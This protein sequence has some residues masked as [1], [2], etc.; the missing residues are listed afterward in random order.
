MS[1]HDAEDVL[2]KELPTRAGVNL[3]L[4]CLSAAVLLLEISLTRYFSFRLWYHYAFMIISIAMLGLTGSSIVLAVWRQRFVTVP[5]ELVASRCAFLAGAAIIVALPG[6]ALLNRLWT[7][8]GGTSLAATFGLVAGYWLLLVVPFGFAGA[9]IG[10]VIGRNAQAA[11]RL[12]AFDLV[13]ASLGCL[14][15]VGLLSRLVPERALG[16]VAAL[17]AVA[18]WLFASESGE[19]RRRAAPLVLGLMLASLAVILG[20]DRLLGDRVTAEKGLART[21][22]GGGR[23]VATRPSISGRVDVA[24]QPGWHLIWGASSLPMSAMPE[25]LL[26]FI[27]GDALTSIT[28]R[29]G[30]ERPLAFLKEMPASLP[31]AVAAPKR[32]LIIGAGGGMDVLNALAHGSRDVTGVEINRAVIEMVQGPFAG[33]S[34]DLYRDPRVRVV[35]SDG[36]NFAQGA[37]EKYDLIQMTLDDS[38]AAISS[39]ALTLAEDFLYTTEGFRAYIRAL[40]SDGVLALGRTRHEYLSLVAMLDA[41]ASQEGIDVREHLLLA[42]NP[43]NSFGLVV[44]FQKSPFS[45]EQV[46]A[47]ERFLPRAHLQ[48]IY[49]P[50]RRESSRSEVMSLLDAPN[51]AQFVEE[52]SAK[53]RDITPETDEKPFYFRASKWTALLGKHY[54]G[55]GTL[56]VILAVALVFVLLGVLMPLY[57]V[58]GAALPGNQRSLAFFFFIG[59]GFMALEMGLL[60]RLGLYLGHPARAITVAL[61]GLLISTGLGSACARS[62]L[63]GDSDSGFAATNVR[64]LVSALV[65]VAVLAM[66]SWRFQP[67]VIQATIGWS[68]DARLLVAMLLV[69]PLGLLLGAPMPLGLAAL[70]RRDE[71]LVLWAWGL[72]GSASVLGSIVT[73]IAAHAW[74][75]GSAFLIASTCYL[76]ASLCVGAGA[77][78][79]RA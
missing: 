22:A 52:Y 11:P 21:L 9:G 55:S 1:I 77:L 2:P 60:V 71:R 66:L 59:F 65:A 75:F 40:S 5:F 6:L 67:A 32:V 19:A 43:A 48:L 17:T 63:A 8:V 15:A 72:N 47:A 33:F 18:G 23:I 39:G 10:W 74:G 28:A 56:L 76:L 46:T 37:K 70:E 62:W 27:D 38:F 49:A 34:G 3:G 13:G 26:L 16:A 58:G 30:D 45:P 4:A 36:R 31:Y 69:A 64:R 20:G 73:V 29:T 44:L 41:A 68:L 14:A 25:Q 35:H 78:R 12:Y 61:F 42:E 51:R 57:R 24:A 7:Q 79:A 54:G 53:V 50:Y